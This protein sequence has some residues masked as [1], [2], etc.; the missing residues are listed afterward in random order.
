MARGLL[1]RGLLKHRLVCLSGL[2]HAVSCAS[3]DAILLQVLAYE[4]HADGAPATIRILR[5][6]VADGVEVCEVV[7][8]GGECLLFVLPS[9]GKIGFASCGF[10]HAFEDGS[11]D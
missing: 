8:D 1:Y 6:V 7:A 4:L 2:K 9:L 3:A 10:A 5:R 11:G